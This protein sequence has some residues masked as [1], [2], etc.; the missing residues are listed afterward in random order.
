MLFQKGA[1]IWIPPYEELLKKY[2]TTE[3]YNY[4]ITE[5]HSKKIYLNISPQ[6]D[7]NDEMIA[8]C[9]EFHTIERITDSSIRIIDNKTKKEFSFEKKIFEDFYQKKKGKGMEKII[10]INNIILKQLKHRYELIEYN[11]LSPSQKSYGIIDS[12]YPFQILRKEIAGTGY[13]KGRAGCIA[14]SERIARDQQ[15]PLAHIADLTAILGY[16]KTKI[17]NILLAVKKKKLSIAVVGYGGTGTNFL[18]W[19]SKIS[20]WTNIN[21][22]FTDLIVSDNDYFDS[23]NL[24]RVPFILPEK[25]NILRKVNYFENYANI[26]RETYTFTTNVI[27]ENLH[28][29]YIHYGAPDL[30]T[31]KMFDEEKIAFIAATHRDNACALMLRPE[32]DTELMVET[33]GKIALTP[34]FMNHI[35]MTLSFLEYL[36]QEETTMEVLRGKETSILSYDFVKENKELCKNG[37]RI[38]GRTVYPIIVD[39]LNRTDIE[40]GD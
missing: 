4:G 39:E 1:T 20:E 9:G 17:K 14:I 7:T 11:N 6:W 12:I 37:G 18:H 15:V 13:V 29:N 40:I 23:V 36:G 25:E 26:S 2:G 28:R 38:N 31:R 33:Y 21:R 19:M 35:K 34:F 32:L 10:N 24:L 22:I 8:M 3:R 30:E 16:S 5:G 27:K